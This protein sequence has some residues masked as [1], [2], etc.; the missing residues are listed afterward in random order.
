MDNTLVT[1]IVRPEIRFLIKFPTGKSCPKESKIIKQGA[2][3]QTK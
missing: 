3:H 2:L 1:A